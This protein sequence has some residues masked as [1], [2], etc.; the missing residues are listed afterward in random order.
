M[1]KIMEFTFKTWVGRL[2]LNITLMK[3]FE[4]IIWY[5]IFEYIRQQ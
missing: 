4:N 5:F 2:H 1:F 3:R